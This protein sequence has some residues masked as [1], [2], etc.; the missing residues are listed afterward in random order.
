MKT[1]TVIFVLILIFSL[2]CITDAREQKQRSKN[3][4]RAQVLNYLEREM[5]RRGENNMFDDG[6]D[7][8]DDNSYDRKRQFARRK[9]V[10]LG[11]EP[12]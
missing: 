11:D 12:F 1:E 2:I 5:E 8:D 6:D 10:G 7:D 3:T 4:L 9:I